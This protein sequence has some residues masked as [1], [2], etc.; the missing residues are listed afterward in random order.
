MTAQ[1]C[2]LI[3][4][5]R[6]GEQ[7]AHLNPQRPPPQ[8]L[9][10]LHRQQRVP[11]ERK[12]VV[13]ASDP[14]NTQKLGPDLCQRDLDL[15][16]RRLIG[17]MRIR[18]IVRR[19]QRLAVQLAVHRQRQRRQPH[20]RRW[21][22]VL[23]QVCTYVGAQGAGKLASLQP[24]RSCF[25]RAHHIGDKT[26]LAAGALVRHHHRLAHERVLAKPRRDLARLDPEA[27][28]LHLVVVA[29]QKLQI[30]VR[31][32]A[33]QIAGAVQPVAVHKG[34]GDEPLRGQLGPVQI[35][36]RHPRPANAELP[37]R[38][39]R[40]Q[41]AMIIQQIHPRVRNRTA[42]RDNGAI[43]LSRTTP[44]CHVD[45]SFRRTVQIVQGRPRQEAPNLMHTG[46]RKRL[47]AA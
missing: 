17:A 45:R 5:H 19:S 26:L 9:D 3:G 21:H 30:A 2:G 37:H 6:P 27:A 10:Q 4:Q 13:V 22:H 34:T 42:N 7:R 47:A 43:K 36:A 1:A 44:R 33:R 12:E 8:T 20:E 39:E 41:P 16:L 15:A 14:L 46:G 38:T 11:A 23:R 25:R 32:I 28:D 24:V 29:A 35:T 40:H 31:Q 18:L